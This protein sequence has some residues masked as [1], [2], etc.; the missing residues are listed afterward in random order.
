M[1]FFQ[2]KKDVV[3][4]GLITRKKSKD[5]NRSSVHSPP[6]SPAYAFPQNAEASRIIRRHSS[7][8]FSSGDEVGAKESEK[9]EA[10]PAKSTRKKSSSGSVEQKL[11]KKQKVEKES[12]VLDKN[13]LNEEMAKN[14]NEV[15]E[16]VREEKSH[17]YGECKTL[18]VKV[19]DKMVHVIMNVGKKDALLNLQVS[20]VCFLSTSLSVIFSRFE[21]FCDLQEIFPLTPH[22]YCFVVLLLFS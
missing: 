14:F 16:S 5:S 1:L 18:A 13:K 22:T 19:L 20:F 10:T 15:P 17:K 4:P 9:E 21:A 6:A 8:S 12:V 7:S 2:L 3:Q 11:P